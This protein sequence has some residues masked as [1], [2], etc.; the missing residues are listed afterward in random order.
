MLGETKNQFSLTRAALSTG[1][2]AKSNF[3]TVIGAPCDLSLPAKSK[4]LSPLPQPVPIQFTV[5]EEKFAGRTVHAGRLLSVSDFEAGIESELTLAP[6]SNLKIGVEL[7]SGANPGGEIYAKV[8]GD[9]TGS[10]RQTRIRFTSVSPELKV[11]VRQMAARKGVT[12]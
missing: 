2:R 10:S 7:V 6:L 8:I 5:L 12:T 3:L 4:A 1:G 9:A 11:W